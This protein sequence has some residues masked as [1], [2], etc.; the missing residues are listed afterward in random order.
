MFLL[1]HDG[2]RVVVV[3]V[4]VGLGVGRGGAER[5]KNQRLSCFRLFVF[6]RE[7]FQIVRQSS[8]RA[9]TVTGKLNLTSSVMAVS[10]TSLRV[11]L[12]VS[13]VVCVSVHSL[14]S[15]ESLVTTIR[16]HGSI[17]VTSTV[18]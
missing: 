8:E 1:R 5:G 12:S 14:L 3:V 10:A 2:D 13:S 17:T 4:G 7:D 15:A 18:L 11:R 6:G 9:N 16:S